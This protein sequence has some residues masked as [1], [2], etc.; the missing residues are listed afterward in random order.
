[1][2]SPDP[3]LRV[4]SARR[5]PFSLESLREIWLYRE[6][7]VFLFRR[8][9]SV[10]YKHAALGLAWVFIQPLLL[11]LTLATVFRAP[12]GG[13]SVLQFSCYV[14]TGLVP[15]IVVSRSLSE[16]ASCLLQ[17][18]KLLTRVYFPRV[19]IPM[20]SVL[21]GLFDCAL[22]LLVT[23]P[24]MAVFG[25]L[26]WS[27]LLGIPLVL[28]AT[29]ITALGCCLWLSA[30]NAEFRDVQYVIPFLTQLLF[31]ASPIVY[32]T[33]HLGNSKWLLIFQAN[34]VAYV[35]ELSRSL[36]LAEPLPALPR[37]LIGAIG[38]ICFVCGGFLY[39]R[40]RERVLVDLIGGQS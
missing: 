39:F 29:G 27:S 31:F 18:Q 20:A 12:S 22:C 26:P 2:S 30:L 1:M 36:L 14:F 16:G 38:L 3:P 19:L 35:L 40:W 8:D 32:R 6:L 5:N 15:W 7:L 13:L 34:P 24:A 37:L 28:L 23:V 21:A 25:L 11:T 10:R 33:S 9:I 4:F 17:D